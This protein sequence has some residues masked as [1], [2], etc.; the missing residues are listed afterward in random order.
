[1]GHFTLLQLR[2]QNKSI[3]GK[4]SEITV[5]VI[6]LHQRLLDTLPSSQKLLSKEHSNFHAQNNI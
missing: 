2:N 3:Q 6:A 4:Q 5:F 1:M